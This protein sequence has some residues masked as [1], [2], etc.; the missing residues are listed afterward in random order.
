MRGSAPRALR[1]GRLKKGIRE[2]GPSTQHD[3]K[4]ICIHNFFMEGKWWGMVE[5]VRRL[6][7]VVMG[8]G[9]VVLVVVGETRRLKYAWVE[10][11]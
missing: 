10:G 1:G 4:L 11:G 2:S 6:V 7:K 8:K 5:A 3:L 9:K